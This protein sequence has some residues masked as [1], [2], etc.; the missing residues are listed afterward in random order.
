MKDTCRSSGEITASAALQAQGSLLDGV[1]VI[2]DGTNDATIIVY[3]NAS[4]ASGTKLFEAVVAGSNNAELFKLP[5]A[6]KA[7]NGLY[8][9]VAG[10]GASCIVY[11]G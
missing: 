7:E 5:Y 3:D 1:L 4:A 11:F 10:T 2:T 9:S 8:V 6:V